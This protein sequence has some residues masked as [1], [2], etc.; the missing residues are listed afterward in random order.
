MN[1]RERIGLFGG[2]F[3]PI[4]QGHLKAA[5]CVQR[6]AILNRIL[7]IPSYIPPHK[8]SIDIA[9]PENR[10]EMVRL[11][12]KKYNEYFASSIEIEDKQKSYSILTLRKVKKLFPMAKIFFI[13][14][15]DAFLDIE[16][17][18]NYHQVLEE[19][20]FLVI[21]RPGYN[22]DM[23]ESV[24][25][26]QLKNKMELL[27]EGEELEEEMLS[28]ASI[29]LLPIDAL[30]IS[31]TEIRNRVRDEKTI[32]GM[33]APEVENYIKRQNLYKRGK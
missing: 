22:L 6:R 20:F 31:S 30:P 2:T 25:G 17:W 13:I 3:N 7:F 4:H 10:M 33:V 8:S 32:S 29:F 18:K 23:A 21:S 9:S 5:Q 12:L 28:R 19:C 24:L 1:R 14:G 27:S 26:G 11:S 16:T 15:V